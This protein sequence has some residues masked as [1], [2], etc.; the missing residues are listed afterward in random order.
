MRTFIVLLVLLLTPVPVSAA[1]ESGV[2]LPDTMDLGGQSLVLNGLGLRQKFVFD[3]YVGGL[4]LPAANSDADAVL[5]ADEPRYMVMHFLRDVD[6]ES[7]NDAWFEGLEDNT[8]GFSQELFGQF[9]SLAKWMEDVPDQ[10]VLTFAYV[11]GQGTTVTVLGT[12]KGVL[13]GKAFADALLAC[14][15]G[16]EPGPGE[17]FKEAVLGLE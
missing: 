3:V 16:P 7:I 4:Y 5:G 8:P 2:V 1:E 14:W 10:G 12:D 17:S 15:I 11:P 13:P 6:A 9:E